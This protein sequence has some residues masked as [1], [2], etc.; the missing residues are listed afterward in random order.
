MSDNSFTRQWVNLAQPQLGAD[1]VFA[2][3]EFF[4][5][6]ENL[7]KVEDP[8]FIPD[9][10]TDHG[11]WMDGWESRRKRHEGFDYAIVKLG[12]PGIIR[13]VN[14]DTSHFTG[15]FP[16]SASIDVCL[17]DGMPDESASWVRILHSKTLQPD[18]HNLFEIDSEFP[19]NYLRLNI[20]PDGGVARLRVYGEILP[21][22]EKYDPAQL[23]DL[24]ALENGGRALMCNDEHFGCMHNIIKTP[25]GV[26]MGDGWETRRRRTPGYDWAIYSLGRLGSAEKVIVDT[27]FFKGNFPERCS[28]QGAIVKG[29][30]EDTIATQ[31]LFWPHLLPESKLSA[32]SQHIFE[33]QIMDIGPI[34]HIR[35]NIFP[36]GGI[37]RLRI[38]GRVADD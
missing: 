34:S 20:Y 21:D 24:V 8:I 38:L 31:S 22:W 13:G 37:S 23:V 26:N 28:I 12:L 9:R 36:D 27:S 11:K 3:D 7:I 5:P 33:S 25:P 32:D 29:G 10:F 1:V 19:W 35:L 30:S 14:I 18:A 4:A 16:P 2:T 6:K 17:S 15:N